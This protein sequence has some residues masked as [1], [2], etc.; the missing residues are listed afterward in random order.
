MVED[1]EDED[2]NDEDEDEDEEEEKPASQ[3]SGTALRTGG[4]KGSGSSSSK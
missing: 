3:R 4:R 1:F 2:L